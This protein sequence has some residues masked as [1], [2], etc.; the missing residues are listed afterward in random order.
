MGLEE[1]TELRV[2]L[3][4]GSESS[5]GAAARSRHQWQS[6]VAPWAALGTRFLHFPRLLGVFCSNTRVQIHVESGSPSPWAHGGYLCLREAFGP[7]R[8][9][10]VLSAGTVPPLPK[11]RQLLAKPYPA[12]AHSRW[13]TPAFHT[14]KS[15]NLWSQVEP[16]PCCV[17]AALLGSEQRWAR[18]SPSVS[19]PATANRLSRETWGFCWLG[20]MAANLDACR[21]SPGSWVCN[22][23]FTL[24]PRVNEWY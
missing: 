15:F 8:A 1:V 14:S 13:G 12:V 10:A 20:W 22:D 4:C 16:S 11:V 7:G 24:A 17:P 19:P 5:S 2:L 18:L 6:R 23:V 3:Q 9:T 21:S